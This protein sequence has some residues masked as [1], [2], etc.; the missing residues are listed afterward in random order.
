MI[1]HARDRG[2]RSQS[3]LK[4]LRIICGAS[5]SVGAA[6]LLSAC[7]SNGQFSGGT[8]C[9]SPDMSM[10]RPAE[11]AAACQA[12]AQDRT[13]SVSK[14]AN[15]HYNL[16][17]AEFALGRF[18]PAKDALDYALVLDPNFSDARLALS[19]V[20]T[21]MG[22]LGGALNDLDAVLAQEP[23]H[24]EALL[25]R[26]DV[27]IRRGEAADLDK[28]LQDLN[29]LAR[30]APRQDQVQAGVVMARLY[31]T[32]LD[33]AQADLNRRPVTRASMMRALRAFRQ[34][35]LAE[36]SSAPAYRG[37]AEAAARM[38]QS[39]PDE[40]IA[41]DVNCEGTSASNWNEVSLAAFE[42]A[43][44]LAPGDA[45]AHL[46]MAEALLALG[47]KSDARSEFET[48]ATLDP[49]NGRAVLG[50]AQSYDLAAQDLRAD[51]RL[52]GAQSLWGQAAENYQD[53]IALGFDRARSH[54]ALAQVWL[55]LED[56]A[57]AQ[58]L[59]NSAEQY[60]SL[61]M[62][63]LRDAQQA[64][65]SGA[66]T[67]LG[68][69]YFNLGPEGFSEAKALLT[70]LTSNSAET[71]T[72]RAK[73]HY[74]LSRMAVEDPAAEQAWRRA[75]E[76]ADAAI[77]LDPTE[78]RYFRQ[79]CLA[80]IGAGEV[81]GAAGERCAAA[82]QADEVDGR[83]LLGVLHLRRAQFARKDDKKREWE[84]AFQ[85]FSQG[86]E[87][88]S[89]D[90]GGRSD[91]A[92]LRALLDTGKG[93]AQY[94]VGFAALGEQLIESTGSQSEASR[95]FFETYRVARCVAY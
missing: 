89:R 54:L 9:Y 5:A 50:V 57:R 1:E 7:A 80:L 36:P 10:A 71:D 69:A 77:A 19:R 85:A 81:F 14:L 67:L 53:A 41:P 18:A 25:L 78:P 4:A 17:R 75:R 82:G 65:A 95:A 79:A 15:A 34:A 21:E 87:A 58:G 44:V 84:A 6:A 86:A 68:E 28:A 60:H 40:P 48:A 76:H 62:A 61:A 29:I 11:A 73:A 63:S 35:R 83:L 66:K 22:D 91:A 72:A 3:S 45:L 49:N 93:V 13:V 39:F 70:P 92:R 94:C 23:D 24:V 51:G 31:E 2:L 8:S 38:A 88:L 37:C 64:G 46:G 16:G 32:A 52:S 59:A 33:L 42:R 56:I 55:N 27:L 30:F 12:A 20:K 26:A 47:R 43:S 74:L 90:G